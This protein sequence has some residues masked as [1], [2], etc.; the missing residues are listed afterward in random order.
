MIYSHFFKRLVLLA[1]FFLTG[2]A[3][4]QDAAYD[5]RLNQ[6]TDY[7][8]SGRGTVHDRF[9]DPECPGCML[10]HYAAAGGQVEV[11][12]VLLRRGANVNTPNGLG[13]ASLHLASMNIELEMARFLLVNG[14]DSS[15]N[16][17]DRHGNT[18]LLWTASVETTER[19]RVVS[20]GTGVVYVA[21]ADSKAEEQKAIQLAELLL[22]AGADPNIPTERGNTPLHIAAYR[23]HMEMVKFLLSKG[24]EPSR[25]NKQGKTP[26]ELA[27]RY[28]HG[29]IAD[30]LRAA[31]TR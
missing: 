5:G 29:D 13:A 31:T 20:S 16:V 15:L 14:A 11:A 12:R 7:I 8:S 17:R 24:A 23:G 28:R 19:T 25:R 18:P 2:C 30:L 26:E 27:R 4:V 3:T 9:D 6:V 22:T 1:V 10:L 21:S